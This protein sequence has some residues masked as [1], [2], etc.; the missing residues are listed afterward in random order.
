MNEYEFNDLLNKLDDLK[1]RCNQ[2][3]LPTTGGLIGAAIGQAKSERGKSVPQVERKGFSVGDRVV[4]TKNLDTLSKRF[5]K[6]L[7]MEITEVGD[8]GYDLVDYNGNCIIE[9][10]PALHQGKVP[11]KHER[12][13]NVR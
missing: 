9:V 13:S 8:R 11:F 6:G 2:A 5:P 4:L 10:S 12:T 7:R 1:T 3:G